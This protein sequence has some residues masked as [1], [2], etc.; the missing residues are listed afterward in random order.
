MAERIIF[1]QLHSDYVRACTNY[2]RVFV[3]QTGL[4]L[5][6]WV[7]DMVG[8]TAQFGDYFFGMEE[9]KLAVDEKIPLIV[10]DAWYWDQLDETKDKMNLYAYWRNALNQTK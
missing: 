10:L 2:T 6:Y 7:A 3:Q 9:I 8:T 4:V 5:D 1:G